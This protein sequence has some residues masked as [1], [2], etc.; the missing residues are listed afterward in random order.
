MTFLIGLFFISNPF[1]EFIE[2]IVDEEKVD[3]TF[4][5]LLEAEL[6]SLYFKSKQKLSRDFLKTLLINLS[7]IFVLA[8]QNPNKMSFGKKKQNIKT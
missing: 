7:N 1:A 4:H 3:E 5:C 6:H 2:D 8:L